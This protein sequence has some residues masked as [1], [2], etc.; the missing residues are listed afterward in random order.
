MRLKKIK[1]YNI[2]VRKDRAGRE[3]LSEAFRF[4]AEISSLNVLRILKKYILNK[5]K[6]TVKPSLSEV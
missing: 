4:K 1:S 6:L 3:K 2:I 5:V